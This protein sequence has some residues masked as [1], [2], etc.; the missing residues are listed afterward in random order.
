MANGE[1]IVGV[2]TR[3]SLLVF[4]YWYDSPT[5]KGFIQVI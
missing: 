2:I 3:H 1:R 5:L 4:K